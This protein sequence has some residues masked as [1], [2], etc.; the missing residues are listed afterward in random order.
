MHSYFVRAST[1]LMGLNDDA[2]CC[3]MIRVVPGRQEEG[4][5]LVSRVEVEV[6]GAS[7]IFTGDLLYFPSSMDMASCLH[8]ICKLSSITQSSVL[9]CLVLKCVIIKPLDGLRHINQRP[10]KMLITT[11]AADNKPTKDSFL[12]RNSMRCLQC[13]CT[14]C[15]L[16]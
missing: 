15:F 14:C 9:P 1:W 3:E 13:L 7:L 10:C 12:S 5:Y 8:F 6:R 2:L 11:I 4:A 16:L